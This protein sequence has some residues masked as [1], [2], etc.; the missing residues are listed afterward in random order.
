MFDRR[1]D[2]VMTVR[3]GGFTDA[4]NRKI[5]GFGAAGSENDFVGVRSDQRRDLS[6]RLVD[7]STRFLT[8]QV[9]A[10]RVTELLRQVRQHRLDD[11]RVVEAMLPYLT[12]KFGN[13]SSVHLFGQE[14]RAAVDKARRQIAALIGAHANEIVFTS[15]G[16]EANN[17]AINGICEASESHGHH[18]IT[19][20]I[21]H[22]SVRGAIE[23]FEKRGWDVT[24]LPVYDDGIVRVEDVRA[25]IRPDTI[26]ISVMTANNEIG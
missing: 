15:G 14:A 17:L 7:S 24:R 21:E 3:F 23:S 2:D 16:T 6:S 10:R 18:I 4:V 25:A 9:N 13:A 1:S 20:A 12:E 8:E 19:S 22:P 11:S 5:V 26:L